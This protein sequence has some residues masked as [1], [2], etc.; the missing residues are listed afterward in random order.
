[1]R[2][3]PKKLQYGPLIP[4]DTLTM[5]LQKEE[6]AYIDTLNQVGP[7]RRIISLMRTSD[8]INA[9]CYRNVFKSTLKYVATGSEIEVKQFYGQVREGTLDNQLF[10]EHVILMS[11]EIR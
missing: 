2:K 4:V 6:E 7:W 8:N 3:R 5:Q 10:I 9:N 11:Q 1:M